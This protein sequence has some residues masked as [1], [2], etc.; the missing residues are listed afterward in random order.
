MI[1][2]LAAVIA[3]MLLAS[4]GKTLGTRVTEAMDA[5]IAVRNPAFA[6]GKGAS[7]LDT[8]LP[9]ELKA[10][11]EKIAYAR[12]L[13]SYQAIARSARDQVTLVCALELASYYR[14]GDV[15]VFLWE[16]SKHPDAGVALNAKRLLQLQDPLPGSFAP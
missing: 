9:P 13:N 10:M 3:G 14:H 7:A 6:G 12:A 4:C 1:R 16:Y 5:C 11:A 8:P 2:S 15:A